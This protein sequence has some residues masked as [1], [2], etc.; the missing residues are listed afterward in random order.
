MAETYDI[1]NL[2]L[3]SNEFVTVQPGDYHFKVV[4]HEID[5]Y[6]GSSEKIPQGTQIVV[7]YLEVPFHDEEG[8]LQIANIRNNLNIYK[9]AMFV[10]RQ[11]VECIGLVGEKGRESVNLDDMDGRTGICS[12]IC[13]VYNGNEYNNV[14]E[15]Y[16]P[17]KAPK[18]TDNDKAWEEYLKTKEIEAEAKKQLMGTAFTPAEGKENIPF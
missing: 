8:N 10:V 12:L 2:T 5:Y 15:F 6:S 13:N 7:T 11:F 14:D 17:S 9:K 4:G 1:N 18:V 3:D 16:A